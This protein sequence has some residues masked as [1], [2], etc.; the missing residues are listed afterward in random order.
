MK[1]SECD[2]DFCEACGEPLEDDKFEIGWDG[3]VCHQ[4]DPPADMSNPQ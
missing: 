3:Q 4:C 1:V 2:Q